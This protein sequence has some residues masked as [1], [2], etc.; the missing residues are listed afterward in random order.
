[1]LRSRFCFCP[2]GFGWGVRMTQAAMTGCIPVLPN[3]H[4]LPVRPAVR[5][6]RAHR[7]THARGCTHAALLARQ[8][9]SHTGLRAALQVALVA[10]WSQIWIV[11]GL[12]IHLLADS[13]GGFL[14]RLLTFAV[15]P[16]S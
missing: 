3:D 2:T 1:M 11:C 13:L 6:A 7:T 10:L 16:R 12:P 8:P 9:R 5:H 14:S 4:V 15:V